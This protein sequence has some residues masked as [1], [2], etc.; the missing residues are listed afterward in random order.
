MRPRILA[1]VVALVS[2]PAF[3]AEPPTLTVVAGGLLT[4]GRLPPV[5]AEA[6]VARHLDT[7]LTTVFQLTVEGRG[8]ATFRGAAQVSVRYDLWDE[9]YRAEPLDTGG[10]GPITTLPT[11]DALQQCWLSLVLSVWRA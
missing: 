8:G 7:G 6:T 3:A 11:R 5:L 2:G 10:E 9:V 1:V 4:V